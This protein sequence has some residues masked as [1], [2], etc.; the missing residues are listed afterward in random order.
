MEIM[1]GHSSDLAISKFEEI[2]MPT[3][4]EPFTFGPCNTFHI[5]DNPIYMLFMLSRY[6]FVAKMFEGMGS[7]LE[8]GCHEGLGGILVA[9]AVKSYS[10]IDFDHDHIHSAEDRNIKDNISYYSHDIIE[11][12]MPG[13]DGVFCLDVLEHIDPKQ[14]DKFMRNIADC[15]EVAIIGTPS[16]D[17][18]KYSSKFSKIGHI[19]CKSGKELFDLCKRYYK[20]VFAFSMNDEVVHTGFKKMAH[21]LFTLCVGPIK[22]KK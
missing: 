19:N 6:K 7:I 4:D 14:E 1:K 2:N 12:A 17:A 20:N 13:Y 21:Y 10:G 5:H 11:S 18:Q 22:E 15:G 9:Q 8:V 3:F 16:K